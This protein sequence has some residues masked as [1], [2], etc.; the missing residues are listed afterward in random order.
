LEARVGKKKSCKSVSYCYGL[1]SAVGRA[2]PEIFVS[3]TLTARFLP[4]NIYFMSFDDKIH[5][6]LEIAEECCRDQKCI[7][8][9]VSRAYY[10]SYQG[11]K[12]YL[13]LKGITKQNYKSVA[14]S[15]GYSFDRVRNDSAFAHETIWEVVKFS[16]IAEKKNTAFRAQSGQA[17]RDLR[18]IADYEET[19]LDR[20]RLVNSILTA[21]KVLQELGVQS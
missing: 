7:S 9:G 4:D 21:K 13:I 20:Q 19:P 2:C 16:F 1:G 11:A 14:V 6:N 12:Q 17:L 3:N 10:A 8:A 15:W 18:N 5:Q